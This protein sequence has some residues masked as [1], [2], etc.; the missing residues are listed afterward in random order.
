MSLSYMV[1]KNR[2][3]L[4]NVFDVAHVYVH[5]CV[6]AVGEVF[7]CKNNELEETINDC[8]FSSSLQ[9]ILPVHYFGSICLHIFIMWVS[10]PQ[11]GDIINI[12]FTNDCFM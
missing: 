1:L 5:T 12:G 3:K 2:R 9:M 11:N 7:C 6:Y 4:R 10:F 8:F